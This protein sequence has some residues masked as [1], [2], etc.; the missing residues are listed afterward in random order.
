M[1]LLQEIEIRRNRGINGSG[2]GAFLTQIHRNKDGWKDELEKL[3]IFLDEFYEDLTVSMRFYHLW[4]K[5]MEIERCPYCD[6]PKKIG[7]RKSF[8]GDKSRGQM[9]YNYYG[10]CGKEECMEKYNVQKTKEGIIAK[11]GIENIWN[12]P[13]Y[14]ES[15][16]KTN[17]ER[18]GEKYYTSTQKFREQSIEAF[19]K[20][21]GGHP[22]KDPKITEKRKATHLKNHGTEWCLHYI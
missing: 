21:E 12:I 7:F 9:G 19:K 8:S 2:F 17:L 1:N 11:Y 13:G 6:D 10:T 20:Y 3:T 15:L 14:R 16:E 5:Q 22:L 4:F 18:H